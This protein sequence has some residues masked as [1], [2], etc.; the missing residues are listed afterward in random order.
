MNDKGSLVCA[1][2]W[3]KVLN[4]I[5][6]LIGAANFTCG[7]QY[8]G[9]LAACVMKAIILCADGQSRKKTEQEQKRERASPQL[10]VTHMSE[11][12]DEIGDF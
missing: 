6:T 9:I 3:S 2:R 10:P 8:C 5:Q 1:S 4:S 12:L 7:R 11:L